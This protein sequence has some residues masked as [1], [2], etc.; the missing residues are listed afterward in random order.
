MCQEPTKYFLYNPPF[1]ICWNILDF[2]GVGMAVVPEGPQ[3]LTLVQFSVQESVF[4]QVRFSEGKGLLPPV[5][6]M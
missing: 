3:E 6:L 1:N 2:S 4:L 5:G